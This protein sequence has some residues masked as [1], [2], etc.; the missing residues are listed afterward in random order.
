MIKPEFISTVIVVRDY[1]YPKIKEMFETV[2]T[3]SKN[4]G[5]QKIQIDKMY[6]ETIIRSMEWR[7]IGVDKTDTLPVDL[8]GVHRQ[9]TASFNISTGKFSFGIPVGNTGKDGIQGIQGVKG[10]EGTQGAK[11]N[12]GTQGPAGIGIEIE[13]RKPI[14]EINLMTPQKRGETWISTTNGQDND[15]NPVY[16][17]DA[18]VGMDDGVGGLRWGN[19]GPITGSDG[20]Q[21]VQGIKG[22]QGVQGQKGGKGDSGVQGAQG[23]QGVQGIQ[24][25]KGQSFVL[26]GVDTLDNIKNKQFLKD[27]DIWIT[28]TGGQID[29]IDYVIHDGVSSDGSGVFRNVGRLVGADAQIDY[30]TQQNA[31]DRTEGTKV[32]TPMSIS[33]ILPKPIPTVD[34]GKALCYDGNKM[35]YDALPP[36]RNILINGHCRIWQRGKSQTGG[37]YQSIDRFAFQGISTEVSKIEIAGISK[38]RIVTEDIGAGFYQV[39]ENGV[40]FAKRNAILSFDLSVISSTEIGMK[41]KVKN[42]NNIIEY[43]VDARHSGRVKLPIVFPDATTAD[44][45][46]IMWEVNEKGVRSEIDI[47][48]INLTL[49]DFY[50]EMEEED[51]SITMQRCQRYYERVLIGMTAPAIGEPAHCYFTVV[52]KRLDPITRFLK[53]YS[54]DKHIREILYVNET[55]GFYLRA[56]SSST[57]LLSFLWELDGEIS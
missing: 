18:M 43:G 10:D 32:L 21:G 38:M 28:S 40:R 20:A 52:P 30:A 9:A 6:S 15:Y 41:I 4:V 27:G 44:H 50:T 7:N 34:D 14:G 55:N 16:T 26:K 53:D 36:K 57:T 3:T 33:K 22:D 2:E 29:S 51:Y 54:G 8:N 11:G 25:I 5:T 45:T 35:L 13:G 46:Y 1:Y 56:S 24:G 23:V 48:K 17:R 19:I 47:F 39:I 37:G 42:G 12:D 31:Y 49:G